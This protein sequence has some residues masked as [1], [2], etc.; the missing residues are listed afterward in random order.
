MSTNPKITVQATVFDSNN[1]PSCGRISVCTLDNYFE[2][3][4]ELRVWAVAKKVQG[5]GIKLVVKL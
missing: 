4:E 5:G 3:K 1:V 2:K